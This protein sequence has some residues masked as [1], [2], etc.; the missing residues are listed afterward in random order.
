[1]ND[2]DPKI[3]RETTEFDD[4]PIPC[5][6]CHREFVWTA[7]E[8]LFYRDKCLQNPPKRCKPCKKLKNARLAAIENA[9]A[10]GYKRYVEVAAECACC[11]IITT[12]PFYPSQGRPIYCRACF[13]NQTESGKGS[14][15]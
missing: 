6:D 7:G 2:A 11:S 12:V 5:V 15:A 4:K 1:M 14:G 13:L 3:V 10:T 9:Q 8:Q